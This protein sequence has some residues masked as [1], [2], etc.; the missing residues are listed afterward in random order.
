MSKRSRAPFTTV[1]EAQI[2]EEYEAGRQ[3]REIAKDFD[4]SQG[5]ISN[6]LARWGIQ[7]RVGK[8]I[9]YTD[10]NTKFFE[11]I[12]CEANAYFLG[13]LYADGGIQTY[14]VSLK[15]QRVDQDIIERFRD[16]MCPSYELKTT[17][18][19]KYVY[20][21]ANQKTICDQLVALGCGPRKSLTL[22]FPTCVPSSLIRHFL[23]GYSDGDGCITQS[24]NSRGH[25]C[26][27]WTIVSTERF[28]Q[29]AA[30]ILKNEAGINSSL[31]I[32]DNGI[33]TTLSV[34]G[35]NQVEKVLDWLYQDATMYMKRKHD[36][37]LNFK[38]YKASKPY[39]NSTH[40][41]FSDEQKQKLVALYESGIPSTKLDA[42]FGISKPS[43]LKILREQGV[44]LRP[45]AIA[46]NPKNSRISNA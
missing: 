45:N 40:I 36:K 7:T 3:Q 32:T 2:I 4:C 9:T 20:F 26:Y 33:T 22:E 43:V 14:T 38:L 15:L 5:A 13:L 35:N 23:R 12:D 24:P 44:K 25:L 16:I 1:E 29:S 19:G 18:V 34:S 10:L 46:M 42:I 30:Q 11:T 31:H 37:Y 39:R 41:E 27:F 28:C 21:R 8:Q 17:D 6:V